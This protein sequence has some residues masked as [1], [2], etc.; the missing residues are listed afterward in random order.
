MDLM[1]KS[2]VVILSINVPLFSKT[3]VAS[4]NI[5]TA[6]FVC[7]LKALIC[8]PS[9][10]SYIAILEHDRCSHNCTLL[11]LHHSHRQ[12]GCQVLI[13]LALS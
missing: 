2:Q 6:E 11:L 3:L 9:V 7:A 10:Q 13:L 1:I 12:P 8:L 5:N 4:L